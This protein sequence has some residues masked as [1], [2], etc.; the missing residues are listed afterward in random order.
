[1]VEEVS[2]KKKKERTDFKKRKKE[3]RMDH[4]DMTVARGA[5]GKQ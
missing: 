2:Q 4:G 1:L 3:K 5:F